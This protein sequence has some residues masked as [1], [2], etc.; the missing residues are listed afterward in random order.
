[1]EDIKQGDFVFPTDE[2]AE[3]FPELKKLWRGGTVQKVEHDVAE[4]HC[5]EV[6]QIH[7]SKLTNDRDGKIAFDPIP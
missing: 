2:A 5:V 1:M 6:H 7:I 3:K 4:I